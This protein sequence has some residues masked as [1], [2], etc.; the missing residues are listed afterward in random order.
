MAYIGKFLLVI[1]TICVFSQ[2]VFAQEDK[3]EMD[4]LQKCAQIS[5]RTDRLICYD[6]LAKAKGY[7]TDETFF[8]EEQNVANFGFWEITKRYNEIGQEITYMKLE[9]NEPTKTRSGLS[10]R[11][12][13]FIRC[14]TGETDVYI[15][16]KD[17]LIKP[18]HHEKKH[19]VSYKIDNDDMVTDTWDLA[20]DKQ[21]VFAPDPIEF[22]KMLK[23]KKRMVVRITPAD[24]AM[25]T[26]V[27]TLDDIDKGLDVL[28]DRCYN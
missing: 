22:V 16:W 15:D 17:S 25:H 9:S 5:L 8:R 18:W 2:P 20:V 12:V 1:A 21:A 7:I 23:N 13:F 11:P 4:P 19:Y 27:F 28:V 6:D 10:L 26:L 14:T 3:E 24:D